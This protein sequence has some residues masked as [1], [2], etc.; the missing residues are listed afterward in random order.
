MKKLSNQAFFKTSI[1]LV[2]ALFALFSCNKEKDLVT[3]APIATTSPTKLEVGEAVNYFNQNAHYKEERQDPDFLS[4]IIEG[5]PEPLWNLATQGKI[6]TAIGDYAFVE[7][8]LKSSKGNL[9]MANWGEEAP[10]TGKVAE[11]DVL[12][13]CRLVITKDK[14]GVLDGK[15]MIAT[16]TKQYAQSKLGLS[17]MRNCAFDRP[18]FEFNGSTMYFGLDGKY[19]KG[20]SYTKGKPVEEVTITKKSAL[21]TRDVECS[22]TAVGYSYTITVGDGMNAFSTTRWDFYWVFRCVNVAAR[23]YAPWVWDRMVAATAPL[24]TITATSVTSLFPHQRICPK[25]FVFDPNGGNSNQKSALFKTFDID[26]LVDQ[27]HVDVNINYA[28]FLYNNN[29]TQ[30]EASDFFRARMQDV[31]VRI[32]AGDIDDYGT[33]SAQ[34]SAI[35]ELFI[36][37]YNN[38]AL[39]RFGM[40]GIGLMKYELETWRAE[41][42]STPTTCP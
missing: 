15:F 5:Q 16:P 29:V 26:F 4:P 17:E 22:W 39:N 42:Y 9:G 6:Q 20:W 7:V 27:V 21:Q 38:V 8:P 18:A 37:T 23:D 2:T 12:N 32:N 3:N 33:L 35:R 36:R 28:S 11:L 10:P 13:H 40:T 34:R 14:N 24:P 41:K 31:Q 30:Q 19:W 25:S 1:V